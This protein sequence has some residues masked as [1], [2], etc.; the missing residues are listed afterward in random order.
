[1]I[2]P[3]AASFKFPA[4]QFRAAVLFAACFMAALPAQAQLRMSILAAGEMAGSGSVLPYDT[5]PDTHIGRG[6]HDIVSAWFVEPTTRYAHGV[7]GDDI[8][9]GG[10]RVFTRDGRVLTYSLPDDSVFEDLRPRVHDIDGDG[11]DEVLVVHSHQASGSALMALGVRDGRLVPIAETAPIGI[12]HRWLNPVGVADVNNDGKLEVLVV[13]TPHIGGTLVVYRLEDGKFVETGRISGVSNHAIGS[14]ELGLSALID[15]DGD[16]I[17]EVVLPSQ[18]R[19]AL[20]A[21]G[22]HEAGPPIEQSRI[23]LPSPA[24]GDFELRP[25]HGMIVPLED[26]R[27]AYI[28]WR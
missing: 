20:R 12:W 9:A 2:P 5:L 26:G 10:L 27:R 17:V 24:A 18:D 11:R 16:G 14:R 28:H 3:K 25:P 8:E 21:F 23:N 19:R 7:L 1:M 4:P 6:R 15:I 13:Q 22:L